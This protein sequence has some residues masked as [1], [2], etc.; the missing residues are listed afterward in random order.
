MK[1]ILVTLGL[2]F[3]LVSTVVAGGFS[4]GVSFT[5]DTYSTTVSVPN[6]GTVVQYAQNMDSIQT[7]G[8]WVISNGPGGNYTL[9][10]GGRV[11][12]NNIP[13]AAGTYAIRQEV[14]ANSGYSF[15]VIS[16]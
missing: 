13:I 14:W 9:G 10:A 4:H 2:A 16:W 3:A 8:S 12:L 15:V 6:A 1:K 11:Q 5:G 7:P